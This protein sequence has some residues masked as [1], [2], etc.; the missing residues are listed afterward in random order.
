MNQPVNNTL[1]IMK[2]NYKQ[3]I[4][5]KKKEIIMKIDLKNKKI[6]TKQHEK[7]LPHY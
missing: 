6:M 2:S 1:Q 3:Y 7:S 4:D 5:V